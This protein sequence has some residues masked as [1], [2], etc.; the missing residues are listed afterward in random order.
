MNFEDNIKNVNDKSFVDRRIN[1]FKYLIFESLSESMG[2]SKSDVSIDMKPLL[3]HSYH[4]NRVTDVWSIEFYLDL[5]IE[6][7]P[8][9]SEMAFVFNRLEKSLYKVFENVGINQFLEFVKNPDPDTQSVGVFVSGI[10]FDMPIV[11]LRI[12]IDYETIT[13]EGA[14]DL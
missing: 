3:H 13:V 6:V 10:E 1:Q 2:I 12:D 5:K 14:S 11:S 7:D 8:V 4:S 9:L